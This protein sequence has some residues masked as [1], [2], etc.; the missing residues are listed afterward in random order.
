LGKKE[1]I[2]EIRELRELREKKPA[3][4]ITAQLM[5]REDASPPTASPH[6]TLF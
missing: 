2:G 6:T 5:G 1:G 3:P 4:R